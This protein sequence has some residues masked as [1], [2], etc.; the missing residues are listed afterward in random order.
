L[1]VGARADKTL[2]QSVEEK[3]SELYEVGDCVEASRITH[4]I[5]GGVEAALQIRIGASQV[6]LRKN[7]DTGLDVGS[8]G[9]RREYK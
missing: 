6:I 3:A 5:Q 9:I 8:L 2:A 4:A 1:A 7:R